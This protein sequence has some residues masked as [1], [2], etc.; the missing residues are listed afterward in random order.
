MVGYETK[1]SHGHEFIAKLKLH[2]EK[3]RKENTHIQRVNTRHGILTTERFQYGKIEIEIHCV[4]LFLE[5]CE[6]MLTHSR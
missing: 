3:K 6:E 1:V 2:S 5:R 4:M